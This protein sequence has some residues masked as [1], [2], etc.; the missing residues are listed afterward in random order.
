MIRTLIADDD[1]LIHVTL[2]S[3]IDWESCGCTVVQSC[4]GGNQALS[5]L[6]EHPVDLLITD[7]KMPGMDGLELMRQLRQSGS[8]PV[9]VVLSGYDEFELVREAF[10]LGAY[11]YLLKGGISRASLTRLL[12]GLREKVFH[13]ATGSAA[14]ISERAPLELEEGDYVLVLFTVED[15]ARAAQRFEGNLRE[16][17]EKPMLE[18]VHQIRRLQ[19]RVTVR[20]RTP[21]CYELYYRVQTRTGVQD[22]VQSLTRQIQGLWHDFMNLDT[23]AGISAVVSRQ[24]LEEAAACCE[25]LCKLSVLQGPGS[26]CVQGR[27][28][29]LVRAYDAQASGCDR[30]IAALCGEEGDMSDQELGRWFSGLKRLDNKEHIR[31]CLV[32]LARLGERLESYSLSFS[33][34]FPERPD[35][36][37]LL[38]EFDSKGEREIWLRNTLRRV[39]E[40]C[41][42]QRQERQKSAIQRAREFMQDNFTNPELMLK[43]VADYVGFSEKYFSTRFTRECGCTF[44]NYLNDLRIRRAQE[45]LVQ[46]DM[47][48]YEISDAVGYSNVEHFNHMFKK[49]LCISPKDFRKSKI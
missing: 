22:T 34:V 35:F 32:L 18:L 30:L 42:S 12:N 9:T 1:S 37:T 47:K 48:I 4:A 44:I 40:A 41:D 36:H 31:R 3:L 27:Y 6:M 45:L 2:R 43:T 7:I 21:S 15:F 13:T 16:Q 24:Q 8:M 14:G 5:Y 46:T 39:R 19:D 26:V 17:M 23:A 28:G 29:E 10:R 49:K 11:D 33:R 38:R 25:T 20:A